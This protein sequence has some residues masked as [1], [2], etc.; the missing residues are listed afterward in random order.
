[1]EVKHGAGRAG[2]RGPGWKSNVREG[3]HESGGLNNG[4]DGGV[5][6]M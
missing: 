1:M 4:L 3:K 5:K 2:K 6:E